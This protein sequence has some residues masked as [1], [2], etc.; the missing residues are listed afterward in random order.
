MLAISSLQ[1]NTT[2]YRRISW[3]FSTPANLQLNKSLTG[4][5]PCP[6]RSIL[7][8]L[9]RL[10]SM[11]S[12]RSTSETNNWQSRYGTATIT[13]SMALPECHFTACWDKDSH[14]TYNRSSLTSMSKTWTCGLDSSCFKSRIRA[15]ESTLRIWSGHPREEQTLSYQL[16]RRLRSQETLPWP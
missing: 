15:N 2:W 9:A 3:G 7:C 1:R 6:S 10:K 13:W 4:D 14:Q 8:Q 11:K 16:T 12:L 5:L